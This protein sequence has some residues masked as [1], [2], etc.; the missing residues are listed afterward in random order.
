M[1]AVNGYALGGGELALAAHPH[2]LGQRAVQACP[3][4]LGIIPGYGGAAPAVGKGARW[5]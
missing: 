1:A 4:T 3:V 5:S 2:G